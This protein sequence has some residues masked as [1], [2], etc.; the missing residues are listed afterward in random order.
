LDMIM[1]IFPLG[2]ASDH[3]LPTY[4][5]C[6]VAILGLEHH[7]VLLTFFP[8]MAL[9][10]HPTDL[11]LQSSWYC[12]LVSALLMFSFSNFAILG[13][14]VKSLIHIKLILHMI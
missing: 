7:G 9:N 5:S 8:I 11:C 14:T 3:D 1:H 4:A 2:P 12:R 10:C 13:V 6:M